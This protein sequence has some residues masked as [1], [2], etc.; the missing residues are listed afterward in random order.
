MSELNGFCHFNDDGSTKNQSFTISVFG[1]DIILKQSPSSVSLGHGA[2]VWDSSIIFAKMMEFNSKDYD[3][4]KMSKKRVI[5]LGSGCGLGGISFLLRGAS[6]TLTDLEKVT[7]T[8]TERNAQN[9]YLQLTSF[10]LDSST[11][12]SILFQ[13]PIVKPIDW[14]CHTI[15]GDANEDENEKYEIV[16]LTDCVFSVE[17]TQ[18]LVGTIVKYSDNKTTVFCCHEIRDEM[19]NEAFLVEFSK[20]FSWKKMPKHKLHPEFTNDQ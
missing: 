2:V 19:A 1:H 8:L 12:T 6:V 11:D 15:S 9:V 3:P 16:L 4:I 14:T 17:L 20:Y 7:S 18:D 5:E 13:K 10:S